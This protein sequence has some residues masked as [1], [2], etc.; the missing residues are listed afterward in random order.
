MFLFVWF[1]SLRPINNLSVI[2]GRVFLGWTSTKLRLM[3]LAQGHNAVMP[4][5]LNS[6][7]PQSWVKH[8]T[9]EPLRYHPSRCCFLPSKTSVHDVF[10]ESFPVCGINIFHFTIV[11]QYTIFSAA[12]LWCHIAHKY[13]WIFT[14]KQAI[15]HQ[16]E[17]LLL[18][19]K[20]IGAGSDLLLNKIKSRLSERRLS[21]TTGLFEDDGQ[22][23]LISTLS[24]AIKLPIIWISII[25]KFKFLKWF[26]GPD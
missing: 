17:I 13:Y 26:V 20:Q 5:R 8:S 25:R 21:E 19:K 15:L 16:W 1:D 18:F 10:T 9:T 7:A 23:G 24:I 12:W 3:C 2:K 22:S 6:A 11:N 4:M 14:G